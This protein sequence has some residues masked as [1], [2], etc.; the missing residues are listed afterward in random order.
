MRLSRQLSSS[1][2]AVVLSLPLLLGA[3]AGVADDAQPQPSGQP[4]SQPSGQPSGQSPSEPSPKPSLI[5]RVIAKLTGGDVVVRGLSGALST[6]PHAERV[7]IRDQDGDW[8]VIQDL[9]LDWSPSRLLVKRLLI[10]RLTAG[11]I[12]LKRPRVKSSTAKSSGLPLK[13]QIKALEVAR[14]Q[15]DKP[16]AG[17]EAAFSLAG[18]LSLESLQ[19]GRLALDAKALD[20]TGT[21]HIEGDF[22]PETLQAQLQVDESPGG[23]LARLAGLPDLGKLVLDA[24][25]QGPRSAIATHVSL[26]AGPMSAKAQGTVD[27]ANR[28]ADLSI[29]ASAPAMSPRTGLSW[30]SVALQA[31]LSGPLARPSADGSLRIAALDVAGTRVQSLAA[32]VQG[33]KGKID[34]TASLD[35]VLIPGPQP[36]V[37]AAAPVSIQATALLDQPDRPL[38]FTLDHPLIVADGRL[39]TAGQRQA[40]VDLRLPELAPLAAIAGLDLQGRSQW[41]LRAAETK[42]ETTLSA[43]GELAVT[44]GSPPLPGLLGD[45]ATIAAAGSIQGKDF[46]LSRLVLDGKTIQ[47]SAR[48]GLKSQA[49]DIDWRLALAALH[50]LDP[51]L[52]GSLAANGR[53]SGP[54]DDLAVDARLTGDLGVQDLPPSPISAQV[55]LAGLPKKPSG[56]IE[57]QGMLAGAPLE[58][59]ARARRTPAA[60]DIEIERADWKSAHAEGRLSLA[61]GALFPVGNLDLRMA[62]LADL[63]P[64]V[65]QPLTGTIAAQLTTAERG[66]QQRAQLSAEARI[67]GLPDGAAVERLALDATVIEPIAH[68]VVDAALVV[69]GFSARGVAG[70]GQLRIN[71]PESALAISLTADARELAGAPARL[72]ASAVVD[73]TAKQAAVSALQAS[74]KGEDLR[75]L[76]PARI[77]FAKGLSVDKLR[78]GV[79]QA[80]LEAS[81]RITP[82]LDLTARV[83]NLSPEVA[84]AFV[85]GLQATGT[86]QGDARLEGTLARPTGTV[87]LAGHGLRIVTGP[88]SALPPAELTA[89]ADLSGETARIESSLSVGTKTRVSLSGQAPLSRTAP[90][91]L[92]A[93]GSVDLALANPVLTAKGRDVRGQLKL[94][95]GL[96]GTL[97]NPRLNGTARVVGGT[98]QDYVQGVHLSNLD[99]LLQLEGDSIRIAR[100]GAQ[101]GPGTLS[102]TGTVGVLQPGIPID[103]TIVARNARP[104]S[105]D[106]LT[107]NLDADVTARGQLTS[108]FLLAGDLRINKAEIRIPETLPTS[109]ATLD[110]RR[111]GQKPPPPASGPTIALDLSIRAPRQI[112]V[113]GRGLDAELGGRVRVRGTAAHPQPLGS[114]ELLRGGLSLAAQTLEFSKG[115]ISFNGGS[116]TDPSIDFTVS[117]T[118]GDITAQLN[119]G[120]TVKQPTITMTSTPQ[121]PQDEVLAQL[122]FGRP[123]SSL[124]PFEIA[125]ITAALGQLAG[126]TPGNF[127]PLSR[128]REALG[129]SRLTLGT[130]AAGQ[131]ALEAGRYVEPNVY[132]GV[133][134]GA[135][136]GSTSAKVQVDLSKHVKLEGTVGSGYGSATGATGVPGSSIGVIIQ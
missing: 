95:A 131:P 70:S 15:I 126:V 78:I 32:R 77:A 76:S 49:L 18:N 108:R 39:L 16:V 54:M 40:K 88:A 42:A 58:L 68:P 97:S 56:R 94:D 129:L 92:R 50:V 105:G 11:Q 61:T 13:I 132:V 47:L 86:L 128:M 74:W 80:V 3:P 7:E 127:H 28:A 57:A 12:E 134:Q 69:D 5:E 113:R 2:R 110:V 109:V 38:T 22:S 115:E 64:I 125:Q 124:S 71:G 45:A 89:N 100:L 90:M 59:T 96:A 75:L 65:N 9:A 130:T 55:Q 25:L 107:V 91:N 121:L 6:T 103:A 60:T 85:P 10:D 117:S 20:S 87:H 111:P 23:P 52:S 14:F 4:S 44:G 35:G 27:L 62:R 72:T 1:V 17:S 118:N 41:T 79:Q 21:Y 84:A 46:A 99:A 67:G 31:K 81:G 104:L 123:V 101:A 136:A 102:A 43:D 120:G 37:L 63:Q 19:E 53:V 26:D 106:L 83:R 48:G 119:I 114:F 51:S 33:D 24:S 29:D 82:T 112:F 73:A 34:L 93:T 36:D 135:A 122:L 8:L 116:L 66:G 133:E 98:V 30:Q